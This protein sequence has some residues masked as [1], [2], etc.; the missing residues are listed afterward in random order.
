MKLTTSLESMKGA[1]SA[2]LRCSGCTYG[3]WPGNHSFCPLYDRGRTFTE[4]AGGLL[5]LARAV[6]NGQMDF[7]RELADLAYTCT[8]CG[9]CD[10]KC[11][12]VRCINPEMSLSDILR[13]IRHEAVKRGVVPEGP[14]RDMYEKVKA[15]GDLGGDGLAKRVRVPAGVEDRDAATLMVVNATHPEDAHSLE[16]PSVSSR[17]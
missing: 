9:A 12:I 15:K 16:A 5:Y 17:R 11:V 14:I 6:L 3:A 1:I 7:S 8:A 10:G 13:L 4:S 2:C